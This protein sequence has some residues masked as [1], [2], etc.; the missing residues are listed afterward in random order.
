MLPDFEY[1]R[2]KSISEAVRL[3]TAFKGEARI[4]SGGTDL[5]LQ[6][7]QGNVWGRPCPQALVSLREVAALDDIH[8][9]DGHILVGANVTHRKAELSPLVAGKL[10]A[11]HDATAQVG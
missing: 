1:Y 6:M 8:F 4:L 9:K 7:E 2:A 11:L 10:K 3:L 5:F